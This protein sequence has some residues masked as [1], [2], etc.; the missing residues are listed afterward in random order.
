MPDAGQHVTFSI[1]DQVFGIE[2]LKIRE[3]VTY[4]KVTTLPNMQGF[5]KGIVNL[6]GAILPVFDLRRKFHLPPADY[7][8]FHIIIVVEI[9]G[10]MMGVIADEIL[11][12]I[13]LVPAEVQPTSNLPPGIKAEYIKGIGNKGHDGLIVLLDVDRLLGSEEIERLDGI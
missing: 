12:V 1:D 13:E 2:I 9:S 8:S 6:R 10:R 7:T 11:D 3:V 4:R 5:V